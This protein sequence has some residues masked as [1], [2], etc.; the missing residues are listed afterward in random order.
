MHPKNIQI[1]DYNYA[2]PEEKIALFPLRERDAAR[3]LVYKSGTIQDRTFKEIGAA[4]PA[5]SLLVYNQ[6]KVVH[7]R[8][9]F[10]KPTGGKVEVF[11]LEPDSRY[12]DVPTAMAMRG[13]VY[14]RCMIGGAS[15]W[16]QEQVLILER[17]NLEVYAERVANVDGTWLLRLFWN[18]ATL[19]FAEVLERAGN[20]PL[21]P[22]INR[23]ATADDEASYQSVF[24]RESGSVAAPTASLHFT[25]GLLARLKESGI[26]TQSLTLHVGAGTF[27]PVSAETMEG[28]D[29]HAEWMEV[30]RATLNRLLEQLRAS[31]PIIA[32]GTTSC[33]SLE[34]L[35]WI[36]WQLLNGI[37][38][39]DG[40]IAV[41]QWLPYEQGEVDL[42]PI[43]AL[44]A[45][46]A[47]LDQKNAQKLVLRTQIII[48]PGYQFRM[49]NG[50]ITNF[51]QPKSTLLLL[52]SAL[53]GEGWRKIYDHALRYGYR[54][55]SYGDGSLLLP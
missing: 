45:I 35:Y 40:S 2:L 52:V 15:K 8:L 37:A 17:Q 32:L 31:K 1:E 53:V 16:K 33:R 49:I 10:K 30:S 21:P 3:L 19:S 55:L 44:E 12:A 7:A 27:K 50:L 41:S 23:E 18:D 39:E 54:F 42:R 34:S 43:D 4:L 13:E 48:A 47:H 22:Y 25:E 28:H 29:M 26:H 20:V 9:Y 14:W 36:G 51:H 24:A 6:T 38:I 46:L 5:G 11:C